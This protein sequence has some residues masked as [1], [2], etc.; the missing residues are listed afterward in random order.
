[1]SLSRQYKWTLTINYLIFIFLILVHLH[2]Q[3][4]LAILW[5]CQTLGSTIGTNFPAFNLLVNLC[6]VRFSLSPL[7]WSDYINVSVSKES[8]N[9]SQSTSQSSPTKPSKKP[10]GRKR[11]LVSSSA[12]K[13][14]F[15][16]CQKNIHW[17]VCLTFKLNFPYLIFTTFQCKECMFYLIYTVH[18]LNG[19][20]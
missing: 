8:S 14:S 20:E 5:K 1:M 12:Q 18:I 17:H 2:N 7:Y 3:F 11:S 16:V 4:L 9:L 6:T 19:I 10:K 13:N 15:Q